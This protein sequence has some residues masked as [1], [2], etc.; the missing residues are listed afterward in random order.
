MASHMISE[1]RQLV[2]WIESLNEISPQ[3]AVESAEQRGPAL[4]TR[5]PPGWRPST[6][7]DN[8]GDLASQRCRSPISLLLAE[9]RAPESSICGPENHQE[10]TE[11]EANSSVPL[12]CHTEHE[13]ATLEAESALKGRKATESLLESR[14]NL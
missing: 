11:E 3:V 14:S 9:S 5:D 7:R 2:P 8:S 12:N 10:R 1:V 4:S 13:Q 6:V